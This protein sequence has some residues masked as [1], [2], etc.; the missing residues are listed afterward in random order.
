MVNEQRASLHSKKLM[1][2]IPT[3]TV[4]H[5]RMGQTQRTNFPT[6]T[7]ILKTDMRQW[8]NKTSYS[9]DYAGC[10]S[11]LTPKNYL[12]PLMKTRLC[13]TGIIA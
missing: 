8:K 4:L 11:L 9:L 2:L 3:L 12:E 1:S 10:K 7:V 5:L 6:V 13:N